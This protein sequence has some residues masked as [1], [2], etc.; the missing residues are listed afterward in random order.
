MLH[1]RKSFFGLHLNY[2]HG[3]YLYS[4]CILKFDIHFYHLLITGVAFMPVMKWSLIAIPVLFRNI[5]WFG[6]FQARRLNIENS[7]HKLL[8]YNQ[9]VLSK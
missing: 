6:V 9:N 8:H 7:R 5:L 4:V 2:R 1:T 3:V